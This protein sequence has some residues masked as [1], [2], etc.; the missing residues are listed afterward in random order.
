[1]RALIIDDEEQNI[2]LLKAI[3]QRIEG[4]VT[5]ATTDPG[6]ASGLFS[7][8]QPDLVLLDRHGRPERADF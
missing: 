5:I 4:L 1:M 6:Q 3:L 2:M 8:H 7:E